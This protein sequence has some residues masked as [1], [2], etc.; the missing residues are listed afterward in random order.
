MSPVASTLPVTVVAAIDAVQRD[1]TVLSALLDV[2]DAVVVRHDLRPAAHGGARG[3]LRRVVSDAS[4]VLEDVVLP[5]EHACLSCALREDLLP[6]LLRLADRGRWSAAVLAPPVAGE[7][8]P[9]VRALV[10]GEVDGVAVRERLPLAGVVVVMEAA[11]AVTDLVGTDTLAE[12]GL[13][14]SADDGRSVGEVLS[15]QLRAA[16]L[17]L[18]VGACD[19]RCATLL[20]HLVPRGALRFAG[21]EELT[22]ADLLA[23]RHDERV[24]RT[25]DDP[26]EVAPTGAADGHGVWTL[27]LAD[28]RPLHPGRLMD[29]LEEIGSGCLVG[30]GRFWLPGRPDVVGIWDGAGGQLSIGEVGGWGG[31]APS[32]RIVVTGAGEDAPRVRRAFERAL[33]TDAELAAGLAGWAGR[34][35]GFEAWMGPTHEAPATARRD[36]D[37]A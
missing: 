36:P 23:P 13:A 8:V 22:G 7:T 9:V 2:P 37:A 14:H 29:R 24:S 17:V 21:P 33:L 10:L 25:W 20:R 1:A 4:G 26:R 34:P 11:A 30:R 16:D 5:L 28:W 3:S 31:A 35:D 32:T 6:T 18:A 12:R 19:R 15:H 27:D